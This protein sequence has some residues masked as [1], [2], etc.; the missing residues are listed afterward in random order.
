MT[1]EEEIELLAFVYGNISTQFELWIT[2]TFAV[3]IASYIAGHRLSKTLRFGLAALYAMVSVLL[4]L[5]LANTVVSVQDIGGDSV[6]RFGPRSENTLLVVIVYLRLAVWILGSAVT[7]G[8]IL[9]GFK[10]HDN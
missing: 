3:I 2:I 1:I 8:F 10:E 7:L 5:V 6:E 9:T 4:Y